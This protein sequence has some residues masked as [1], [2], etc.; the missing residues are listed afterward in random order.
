AAGARARPST[1]WSRSGIARS[2]TARAA[3]TGQTPAMRAAGSPAPDLRR[4]VWTRAS[5]SSAPEVRDATARPGA[6]MPTHRP[7]ARRR[8]EDAGQSL[9]GSSSAFTRSTLAGTETHR[10]TPERLHARAEGYPVQPHPHRRRRGREPALAP[11]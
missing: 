3:Q 1:R 11:G 6:E 5:G 4:P 8:A 9:L 7:L 10:G 2:E